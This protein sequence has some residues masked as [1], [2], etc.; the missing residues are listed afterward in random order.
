MNLVSSKSLPFESTK[1]VIKVSNPLGKYVLIDKVCKNCPLMTR[2]YYFSTNL[3]FL[4]FDKF[5]VILGMD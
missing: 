1:F 3:M 2:G 5:K 4:P